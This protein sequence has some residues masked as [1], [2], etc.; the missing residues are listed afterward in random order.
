MEYTKRM[1]QSSLQIILFETHG[2]KI[3]NKVEIRDMKMKMRW[4]Q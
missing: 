2:E 4:Q 3:G 1:Q